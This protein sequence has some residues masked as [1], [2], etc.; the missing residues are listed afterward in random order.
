M[1]TFHKSHIF[2]QSCLKNRTGRAIG[3]INHLKENV[4]EMQY[5]GAKNIFTQTV[6]GQTASVEYDVVVGRQTKELQ[7]MLS[8]QSTTDNMTVCT[9]WAYEADYDYMGQ[10][11]FNQELTTY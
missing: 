3:V 1:M 7:S 6:N 5:C 2:H 9:A 11:I 4:V 10:R 8:F